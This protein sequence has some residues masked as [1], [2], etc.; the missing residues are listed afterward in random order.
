MV[1]L[2]EMPTTTLWKDP[3]SAPRVIHAGGYCWLT[4][5]LLVTKLAAARGCSADQALELTRVAFPHDEGPFLAAMT[6]AP[7]TPADDTQDH[8]MLNSFVK[9]GTLAAMESFANKWG[10]PIQIDVG[11]LRPYSL[12]PWQRL[13]RVQTAVMDALRFINP[14]PLISDCVRLAPKGGPWQFSTTSWSDGTLIWAEV[15]GDLVE[16]TRSDPLARDPAAFERAVTRAVA[17]WGVSDLLKDHTRNCL[18]ASPG[19]RALEVHRFADPVGAMALVMANLLMGIKGA[20]SRFLR[21]CQY[22]PCRQVFV[23]SS[24]NQKYCPGT[25]HQKDAKTWRARQREKDQRHGATA[26]AN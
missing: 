19:L 20:S 17:V 12:L 2:K 15:P 16:A 18:M 3:V 1:T 14:G 5:E 21:V 22:P 8:V 23:A 9:A 10:L 7:A 26:A 4:R 24:S 13:Q 25:N 11:Y 6:H